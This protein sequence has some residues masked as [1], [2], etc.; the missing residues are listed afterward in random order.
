ML[1]TSQTMIIQLFSADSGMGL[2]F[3]F[4]EQLKYSFVSPQPIIS[5]LYFQIS[6]SRTKFL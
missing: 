5:F 4:V 3:K 6:S 1:Y 2:Y